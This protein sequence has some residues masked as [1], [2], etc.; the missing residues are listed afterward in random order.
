MNSN[1]I[2]L[3]A[4]VILLM[5]VALKSFAAQHAFALGYAPKYQAGFKY[6][7]YVN[8]TAPKGGSIT[9]FSHGNYGSFNPFL[10][11][12]IPAAGLNQLV[13]ETLLETS[14]DEPFSAYGLLAE[15][16]EL[17]Q[18][19]LAVTFRLN[20]KARFSDA[21]RV[22]AM[23]VK[24]SFDSLMGAKA[25][26]R[27]RFYYHDVK[28]AVVVDE[29]TIRF[30]FKKENPELHM[31]IGQVPV[32]SR[33]WVGNKEFNDVVLEKPIASGPYTI[34]SFATGKNII[35][36]RNENYWGKDLG[37]RL[38][39]FNFDR[40]TYKYFKDMTVALEG[41]KAGDFDFFAENNS[42]RW[43]RD[44]IGEKYDRGLIKKVEFSHKNNAGMQ[45]FIFNLRKPRFQDQRVRQAIALAYDFE[46]A[47]EHLFY[48]QYTRCDSY[49]S[50]S[51]LAASGL[52]EGDELKLLT[53]FREQLPASV[54]TKV[55]QPNSTKHPNSARQNLRA[56]NKLLQQAG[57]QVKA[58]RLVDAKGKPFEF[59]VLLVTKAFERIL[60]PF[61]RN[62]K[63]LG[64]KMRY[65]TVDGAL[66]NER[67]KLFKFDMVISTFG[68]SLSPGNELMGSLHSNSAT[69]NGSRNLTGIIN[70]VVDKLVEKIIYAPDRKQ[71]IIA[72]HALDRVLLHYDYIVPNWYINMHRVAYWDKFAMPQNM[73]L[74]Y[75]PDSWML[76]TWWMAASK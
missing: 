20:P 64:I 41:L 33:N 45:G 76:K 40:I 31:I 60:A 16:M 2:K 59:E 51:E 71:L 23:D 19:G 32:F 63:K 53:P 57:F 15:E 3:F 13:F 24:F 47:N 62:L 4:V 7:D 5:T 72:T 48:G 39:Q 52:P 36:Q 54:F 26:P 28:Q 34:E 6:F 21:S 38:G 42:K 14:L 73:P 12:D 56:A 29:Q 65:R 43:A 75:Y 44:H 46:W 17:A 30:D 67:L 70:P 55:W 8:A 9:L 50:N 74:Y 11:K 25:H 68:G 18:D 66:Y 49:F 1:I 58:G 37:V 61:E 69:E 35:Y 27:Y 22:T 10:L